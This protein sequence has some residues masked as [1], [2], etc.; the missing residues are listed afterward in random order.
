MNYLGK[1][2]ESIHMK[3]FEIDSNISKNAIRILSGDTMKQRQ[4]P[5]E[6]VLSVRHDQGCQAD[7]T[8][9]S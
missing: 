8:L 6:V 3:G 1:F 2:R 7:G 4:R 5:R 9:Q